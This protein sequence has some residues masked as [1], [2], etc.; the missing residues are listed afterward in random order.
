M[1]DFNQNDNRTISNRIPDYDE[2][3]LR[4]EVDRPEFLFGIDLNNND[5]ID[6][7]ENDDEPDFPYKRDHRGYNAYSGAHVIPGVRVSVGQT[8]EELLSSERENTTTYGLVTVDENW[9]GPRALAGVQYAKT[10]QRHHPR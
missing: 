4:Y 1:S 8:R 2:P 7:F 5:W 9:A 6:R 10:G 3:F